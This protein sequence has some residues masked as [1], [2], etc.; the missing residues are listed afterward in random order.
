MSSPIHVQILGDFFQQNTVETEHGIF[1]ATE[2][3]CL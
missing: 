1:R 3:V 2:A